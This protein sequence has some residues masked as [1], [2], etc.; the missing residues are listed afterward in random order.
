MAY[1]GL[2]G[3]SA[4]QSKQ[5]PRAGDAHVSQAEKGAIS[6]N[7]VR[8][9]PPGQ[10]S[11]GAIPFRS[12]RLPGPPSFTN[13]V[14]AC[15]VGFTC[16]S[17]WEGAASTYPLQHVFV[18]DYLIDLAKKFHGSFA[19]GGPRPG[20]PSPGPYLPFKSIGHQWLCSRQRIAHNAKLRV[21]KTRTTPKKGTRCGLVRCLYAYAYTISSSF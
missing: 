5:I 4:A 8:L 21:N 6:P 1:H 10:E 9:D 20:Q 14:P 11:K 19:V 13:P 2:T 16:S 18:C 12:P 15:L 3:S 17:I 7:H